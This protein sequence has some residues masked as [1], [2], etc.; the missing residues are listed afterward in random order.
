MVNVAGV[1]QVVVR[2]NGEGQLCCIHWSY[3]QDVA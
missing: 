2:G 1:G 3:I